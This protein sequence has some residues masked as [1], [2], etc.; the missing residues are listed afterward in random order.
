MIDRREPRFAENGSSDN[1]T[2][3]TELRHAR[4]SQVPYLPLALKKTAPRSVDDDIRRYKASTAGAARSPGPTSVEAGQYL[5]ARESTLS[6]TGRTSM[7]ENIL[8][9]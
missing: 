9:S 4:I 1:V 7:H 3:F 6:S 5:N 2:G 8:R